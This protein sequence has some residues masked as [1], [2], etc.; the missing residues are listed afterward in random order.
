MNITLLR[1]NIGTLVTLSRVLISK[2]D[3]PPT[4]STAI[5]NGS[6]M[7]KSTERE[8]SYSLVTLV[9]VSPLE[10]TGLIFLPE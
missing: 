3:R 6:K 1:R 2:S 7:R 4:T 8:V 5:L 9:I 10:V